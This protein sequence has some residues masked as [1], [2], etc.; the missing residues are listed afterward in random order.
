MI[1]YTV[2]L[3]DMHLHNS[4][5]SEQQIADALRSLCFIAEGIE[6]SEFKVRCYEGLLV[7]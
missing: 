3:S 7:G 2:A 4:N 6:E 1:D 5:K